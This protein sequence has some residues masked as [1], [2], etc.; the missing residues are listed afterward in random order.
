MDGIRGNV[1]FWGKNEWMCKCVLINE[2]IKGV[3]VDEIVFG[4]VGKWKGKVR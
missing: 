3:C 1:R 2:R 4:K